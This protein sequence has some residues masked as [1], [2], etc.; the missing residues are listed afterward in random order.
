MAH[1]TGGRSELVE[2][3]LAAAVQN[4]LHA[5][6]NER[7]SEDDELRPV[8]QWL[9]RLL[10]D[11]LRTDNHWNPHNSVDD[12]SPCTVRRISPC[13]LAFTGLLIWLDGNKSRE[14][15]EPFYAAIHVPDDPPI[16]LIYEI[17]LADADRVFGKCPYDSLH[18]FPYVPVS[19]WL[20]TFASSHSKERLS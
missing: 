7:I 9:A 16:Q 19:N 18:D 13:D 14:R 8:C 10:A 17:R 3:S 11:R 15:K 20:F 4:Y 12:I 2:M 1:M 5:M 6:P